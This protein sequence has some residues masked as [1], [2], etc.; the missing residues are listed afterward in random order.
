MEGPDG[1]QQVARQRFSSLSPAQPLLSDA[2]IARLAALAQQVQL[3][4]AG[5]Y[6]TSPRALAL[7]IEFKPLGEERQLQ[8]EQVRPYAVPPQ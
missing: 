2:E 5:L 6:A 4:F 1:T 7:D 3:R 8:L